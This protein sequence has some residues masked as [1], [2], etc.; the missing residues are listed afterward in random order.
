MKLTA[1]EKKALK[2][3]KKELE[4]KLRTNLVQ[5]ILFGSKARGD[6]RKDSDI[7]VLVIV[8][9]DSE[10]TRQKV[11]NIRMDI[12]QKYSYQLFISA[13][14]MSKKEFNY[15]NSIPTLFAFF[16]KRDGI[17]I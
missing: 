14:V 17:L 3:F 11:N 4:R 1:K 15:Y 5:M 10:L 12:N 13:K 16:I 7:D 2:E 6:A 8:R 9:R